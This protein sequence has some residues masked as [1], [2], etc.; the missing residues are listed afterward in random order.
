MNGKK[1]ELER[2][3]ERNNGNFNFCWFYQKELV[4]EIRNI[5]MD[6]CIHLSRE[7]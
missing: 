4:V 1:I 3:S 6:Q 2:F 5:R 7:S